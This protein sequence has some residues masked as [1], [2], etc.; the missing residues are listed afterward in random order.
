[1]SFYS[2]AHQ[3]W[4]EIKRRELIQEFSPILKADK[5]ISEWA[6]DAMILGNHEVFQS[7]YVSLAL[8]RCKTS[9]EFNQVE[10]R[11]SKKGPLDP[12]QG[13]VI[14]FQRFLVDTYLYNERL[15]W[16]G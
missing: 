10:R 8:L 15:E 1:M 2:D 9:E 3:E 16:W 6:I 7:L 5:E 14:R 4:F 12:V 11:Y 13:D